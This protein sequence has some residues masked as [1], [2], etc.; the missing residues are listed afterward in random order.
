MQSKK[1]LNYNKKY[2]TINQIRLF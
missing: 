1:Q 2:T